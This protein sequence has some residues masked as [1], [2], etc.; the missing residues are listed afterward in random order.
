MIKDKLVTTLTPE[1]VIMFYETIEE[2][3][4]EVQFVCHLIFNNTIDLYVPNNPKKTRTNI[5][6]LLHKQGWTHYKIY[7]TFRKISDMIRKF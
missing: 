1:D 6:N 5:K 4:R 7:K 3:D 2:T